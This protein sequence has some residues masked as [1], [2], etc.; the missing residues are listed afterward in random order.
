MDR[1]FKKPSFNEEDDEI[2]SV[3]HHIAGVMYK[4]ALFSETHEQKIK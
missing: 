1:Y 2:K 3:M 4:Y